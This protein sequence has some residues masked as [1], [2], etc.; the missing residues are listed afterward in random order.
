MSQEKACRTPIWNKSTSKRVDRRYWCLTPFFHG[1]PPV[2]P[3][4][5]HLRNSAHTRR[6]LAQFHAHGLFRAGQDLRP[7]R[8]KPDQPLLIL[9]GFLEILYRI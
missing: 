1:N 5:T 3:T 4:Q 6:N 9:L 2:R 8:Q 7:D